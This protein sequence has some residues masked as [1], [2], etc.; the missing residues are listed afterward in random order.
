MKKTQI[1]LRAFFLVAFLISI[2]ASCQKDDDVLIENQL[3]NVVEESYATGKIKLGKKLE[4]PYALGTMKKAWEN[5]AENF[6]TQHIDIQPTHLYLKFK[7]KNDTELSIL[8][9]YGNLDLYNYPLDYEIKEGGDYYTDPEIEEGRPN[10]QYAAYPVSKQLPKEVEYEVLEELFI[11]NT[12][13]KQIV[14]KK[15]VE[16]DVLGRLEEEALRITGNQESKEPVFQKKNKNWRPAGRIM[17][18][19]DVVDRY[20]PVVDVEVKARRWFTTHKGKT[21]SQGYY[22]GNG[23]FKKDANYS[24]TWEKYEFSVRSGTFGQ[25][26]LNGPKKKGDWNVNLGQRNSS[27]VKDKQQYY[28]LIFQAARDYYYG[29]RFGL[30]SPPKN[31]TLNPQTK[32]AADITERQ[33]EKPSHA[34]IYARTG[35]FLPTIYARTWDRSAERVYAVTAH[36]LAHYSHWNLDRNAFRLLVAQYL[37]NSSTEAVIESWA[38]GV[39]WSFAQ[40]RYRNLLGIVNYNY[41]N[42]NQHKRLEGFTNRPNDLLYTSL[43]MDL[44]DNNNQRATNANSLAFPQDRVTGY[45][46]KQIEQALKGSTSWNQW[47]NNIISLHNNLTENRVNEL[48]GNWY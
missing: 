5:I 43:V 20:V 46:M 8:K 39:E 33:N 7:P 26:T 27:T 2:F 24:I 21:N 40:E 41:S 44:I 23:T 16:I 28:A 17:V 1:I 48:F 42:S 25:A 10:Y 37:I 12:R 45:S 32:I 22:Q 47:R 35:G 38:E 30:A 31:G 29:N 19:D 9:R 3:Q 36:E 15:G 13:Q 6:A 34:A 4:N 14:L 18:W 11:P